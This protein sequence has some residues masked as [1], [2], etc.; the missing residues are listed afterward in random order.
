M[1]FY[2]EQADNDLDNILDGLL[3][4]EKF[5]LT[6]DFCL[7]YVS[8]IIDVCDSLDSL[9]YHAS[10]TYETHKQ[11][12]DKVYAYLRNRSTTWYIIY[13]VDFAGNILVNKIIS[14]HLTVS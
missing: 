13:N 11:Y 14:N 4:W 12:G 7:D 8:S 3:H 2:S 5:A 10:A 1:V 6:Q 9:S